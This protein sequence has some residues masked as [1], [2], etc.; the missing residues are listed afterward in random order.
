MI[1]HIPAF[2]QNHHIFTYYLFA[3]VTR[4]SAEL[5]L[6]TNAVSVSNLTDFPRPISE[7]LDLCFKGPQVQISK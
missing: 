5:S 6:V 7:K 3:L 1:K 4:D 2:D